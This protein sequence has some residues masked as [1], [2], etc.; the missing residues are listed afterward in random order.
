MVHRQRV[1]TQALY[2]RDEVI[3]QGVVDAVVHIADYHVGLALAADGHGLGDEIRVAYAAAYQSRVEYHRLDKA[4]LGA[5]ENLVVLGLGGTALGIGAHVERETG[6]EAL[7]HQAGYAGQ[8][9]LDH[10][11]GLVEHGYLDV[12]HAV[13]GEDM[14][15]GEV[16]G[17]RVV[18]EEL[19]ELLHDVVLDQ[20]VDIE[21]DGFF[22]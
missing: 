18:V 5:S 4:V 16:L 13:L 8:D 21:D 10:L 9:V 19:H 2:P 15:V 17:T 20:T 7:G 6:R 14:G 12:G 22:L 3:E 11:V 1:D